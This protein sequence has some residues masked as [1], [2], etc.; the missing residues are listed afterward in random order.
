MKTLQL[1][2]EKLP[3]L[4]FDVEEIY[5]DLDEKEKL[6][7]A[8]FVDFIFANRDDLL[9]KEFH[10]RDHSERPDTTCL[11]VPEDT[12]SRWEELENSEK[13]LVRWF[14]NNIKNK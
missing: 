7:V 11:T 6:H 13:A 4:E 3:T 2:I 14:I 5:I 8:E 10:L 1:P 12:P 9:G